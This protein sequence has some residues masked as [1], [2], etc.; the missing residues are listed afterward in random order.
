[1]ATTFSSELQQR[2]KRRERWRD[3]SP[4]RRREALT[5]LLFISPWIIGVLV[6]TLGPF[7]ASFLLS[8]TKYTIIQP[9]VWIGTDNYAKILGSDDLF[10]KS[11][12]NTA[13]YVAGS[14]TIRIVLGFLLAMLLNA[15]VR[16]LGLWR[17]LFYVPSVVPIVALSMIWLYVLNG[18]FGLLNWFLGVVGIDRIRWLSDPDYTMLGLL[19]MSTTWVGVTMIIFLAGLQNIPVEYYDAAKIDGAGGLQRMLRITIPLMTPTIF[20]NVL[21]NI[22]NAFQV[23]S[24]V[25]IMTNG[26]PRDATRTFVLHIYDYAF[27]YLPPQMGYSS[28]L[29]WIL[30]MIVFLFTAV[31][32]VTSN[33]WVFYNN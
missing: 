23:F 12:G 21:I 9:P 11:L 3:L 26:G 27:S 14:V 5:G 28:A 33:R 6:F 19:I 18:R 20:L 1:M 13:T 25:L 22:I 15:K 10:W 2:P 7:I 17:T 8:F 16:F 32:V 24:Q 4:M 30:F 29:A 31:I